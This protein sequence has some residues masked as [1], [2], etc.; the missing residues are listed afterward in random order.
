MVTISLRLPRRLKA[1]IERLSRRSGESAY[2]YM[3]RALEA[4]IEAEER[5]QGFLD[6]GVRADGAM[7]RSGLGY[8]AGDVHA[9]LTAKV[10]GRT[11]RRPKPV[12][13]RR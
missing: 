9:Y 2:A 1:R 7:Q 6:D 11:A 8:A 10:E 3:L 13:W 12:R 5:Y 4:F